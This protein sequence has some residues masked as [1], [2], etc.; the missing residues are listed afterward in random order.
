MLP[1]K[2]ELAQQPYRVYKTG[3]A[4]YDAARLIGVAH[5]F[6]GTASAEVEDQGTYWEVKGIE[7]NR[8]EEQVMWAVERLNPTD[9]ERNLFYK[10]RDHSFQ[11]DDFQ[12]FFSEADLTHRSGRK[13]ALKAEYDAALQI[14]TRG[15]DPLA[16]YEVLAPRSTG[17]KRK[18]FKDFYQEVAAATLGRAF[19]ARVTSRTKRQADELYILPIFQK[20][21]VLSGFLNYQRSFSHPAGGWVAAVFASLSILLELTAKRLPVADFAYTREVK[22]PARQPIFSGSGYLGFERLCN[23]WWIAVQANDDNVLNLLRGF[24]AFLSQTTSPQ[25]NE[26]VQSLARWVADFVANPSVDSLT[27]IERLKAR[28]RAASQNRNFPGAYAA[29]HLLNRTE[30]I[31]EVRKMLQSDLPEVPWQVSEALAR[32]LSFD[33]K[34]WMNQLTR[35]ENAPNFSQFIQQVEHIVSRGYYREHQEKGQR[36]NIREALTRAKELANRLR[37]MSSLLQDEKSFR[38]WK[39]IFLLDV[40]SRARI[41]AEQPQEQESTPEG[42]LTQSG[43]QTPEEG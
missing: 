38:A 4:F 41:R 13:E 19:A 28:I 43:I 1:A 30:P 6:L 3:I 12:T 5:L 37:E 39:A 23:L 24:R 10:D 15:V 18:K 33:E 42:V 27:M 35:L 2:L 31:K 7:V 8:D 36:P 40:L 22:G 9:T 29:N 17:E 26:Q 11:W 16:K 14:G 25:T 32:A 34:G 21:F 20:R